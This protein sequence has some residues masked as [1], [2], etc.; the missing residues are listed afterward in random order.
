MNIK[1]K[2]ILLFLTLVIYQQVLPQDGKK[3]RNVEIPSFSN[4]KIKTDWLDIDPIDFAKL[5]FN[6]TNTVEDNSY[7]YD[8]QGINALTYSIVKFDKSNAF[9]PLRKELKLTENA[10]ETV[11]YRSL[12]LIKDQLVL[13]YGA[14]NT[15]GG[16]SLRAYARKISKGLEWDGKEVLID[17]MK[18]KNFEQFAGYLWCSSE[19]RDK[20]L[21]LALSDQGEDHSINARIIDENLSVQSEDV[22]L[23]YKK[24]TKK[25]KVNDSRLYECKKFS[26]NVL[27]MFSQGMLSNAT[28]DAEPEDF[29]LT[30]NFNTK[31]LS[32]ID[33][34]INESK[35]NYIDFVKGRKNEMIAYGLLTSGKG[36][37]NHYYDNSGINKAIVT[38]AFAIRLEIDG[39]KELNRTSRDLDGKYLNYWQPKVYVYQDGNL[40][41]FMQKFASTRLKDERENKYFYDYTYSDIVTFNLAFESVP[42][43]LWLRKINTHQYIGDS[44]DYESMLGEKKYCNNGDAIYWKCSYVFV[45]GPD[46]PI[47][48]INAGDN[49]ADETY[50]KEISLASPRSST[51][52][53][54]LI[55]VGANGDFQ[56]TNFSNL[57]GKTYPV[58]LTNSASLRTGSGVIATFSDNFGGGCFKIG[59]LNLK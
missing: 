22:P 9:A 30:L 55:R 14:R 32:K 24:L 27:Y 47:L 2:Y 56:L 20:I 33:V 35:Y 3:P 26:G 12:F 4:E 34:N 40:G 8:L 39:S 36:S 17:E 54:Y 42:D 13:L 41:F 1:G 15:A 44:R 25:G 38:G 43:K 6:K 11:I 16:N 29:I 52:Y 18:M 37:N 57:F 59:L 23:P 48:I 10:K 46:E 45:N 49:Y 31:K 19:E 53:T 5:A 50:K 28:K 7:I 21:I 58:L 51:A